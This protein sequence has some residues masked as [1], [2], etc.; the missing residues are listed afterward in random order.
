MGT[1]LGRRISE[2]NQV[3][4][5]QVVL[6]VELCFH[7][8]TEQV[9]TVSVSA[10]VVQ[11]FRLIALEPWKKL[12]IQT[13]HPVLAIIRKFFKFEKAI[14]LS[15]MFSFLFKKAGSHLQYVCNNCAKFQIDC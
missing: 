5:G 9:H 13:C 3:L 8:P 14:I 1:S 2:K 4:V 10:T 12:I 11:N 6:P 7:P 15:K